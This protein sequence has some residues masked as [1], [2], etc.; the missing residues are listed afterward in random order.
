MLHYFIVQ[1]HVIPATL[2]DKYFAKPSYLCIAEIFGGI[3][4]ANVVKVT[5]SSLTQDKK[6]RVIKIS[7]MRA[8]GEI[9]ESFHIYNIHMYCLSLAGSI[10]H[11]SGVSSVVLRVLEHTPEQ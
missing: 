4:F 6:I 8:N 7:P 10:N 5:I 1:C 9:G 3:S 11:P 2:H